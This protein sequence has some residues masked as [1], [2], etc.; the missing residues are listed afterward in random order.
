MSDELIDDLDLLANLDQTQLLHQIIRR[1]ARIERNQERIMTAESDTLAALAA[2]EAAVDTLISDFQSVE[3]QLADLQT[4]LGQ[5]ISNEDAAALVTRIQAD[6]AKVTAVLPAAPVETPP[7]DTTPPADTT[8]PVTI[9]D[10]P[11]DTSSG[12]LPPADTTPSVTGED[13]TPP[14]EAPVDAPPAEPTA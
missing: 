5:G 1:L 2:D 6:T 13:T 4:Q 7:V 11:P 14:V 3:Q 12:D 10:T 9:P 8:P